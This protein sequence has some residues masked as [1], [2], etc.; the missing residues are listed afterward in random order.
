METVSKEGVAEPLPLGL[1][2]KSNDVKFKEL[3]DKFA[4]LFIFLIIFKVFIFKK[5]YNRGA[6]VLH[7]LQKF[8]SQPY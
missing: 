2:V 7:P 1:Q 3:D 4:N 5:D 6:R 8:A